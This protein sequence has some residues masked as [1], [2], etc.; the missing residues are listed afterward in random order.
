MINQS[1][2]DTMKIYWLQWNGNYSFVITV[3]DNITNQR[4]RQIEQR[5]MDRLT[6]TSAGGW[7][8]WVTH[9]LRYGVYTHRDFCMGWTLQ[10]ISSEDLSK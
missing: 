3:S 7:K 8:Q 10:P 9:L 6:A 4:A 2:F 5:G 1:V